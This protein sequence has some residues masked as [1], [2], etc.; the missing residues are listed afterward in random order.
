MGFDASVTF[1]SSLV[2]LAWH[3][4]VA[5]RKFPFG[6]WKHNKESHTFYRRVKTVSLSKKESSPLNHI[7][8]N[9]QQPSSYPR[10]A[11]LWGHH[12]A[13]NSLLCYIFQ[14][15]FDIL[16]LY[17]RAYKITSTPEVADCRWQSAPQEWGC[18]WHHLD[19]EWTCHWC[20]RWGPQREQC[21]TGMSVG[22]AHVPVGLWPVAAPALPWKDENGWIIDLELICWSF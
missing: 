11:G 3:L 8:W 5:N 12:S 19:I 21:L 6:C 4:Y 7:H 1:S 15:W 13:H 9:W 10:P 18:S 14:A 22:T 16:H 20:W 17:P 2:V